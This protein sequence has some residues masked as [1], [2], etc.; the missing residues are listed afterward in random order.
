MVVDGKKIADLVLKRL[1][2]MPKPEKFCAAILAGEDSASMSFLKQ[3][4]NAAKRIGVDFRVFRFPEKIESG[5]LRNEAE[6]I[7][8]DENCGGVIVQLPLP[9]HINRHSILNIIPPEKDVDVLGERALGAFY[10]GQT[11]MLPPPAGVVKLICE[12]QNYDLGSH[13][14]AIVGLGLLVGRPIANW[15][16]RRAKETLLLRSAS[17]LSLL[18]HAD[19]VITGIGNAGFIQPEMLKTGAAVIDFGYDNNRG[20]FDYE[21]LAPGDSRIAFYTPTPGG[22]G[23]ILVAELF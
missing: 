9:S 13:G 1:A 5:V 12:A 4:E 7:S 18:T 21:Q 14:V 17:D 10:A 2:Q 23:P 3:K 11:D 15:V 6:K 20:D 8:A 22:T 19:L 16:M